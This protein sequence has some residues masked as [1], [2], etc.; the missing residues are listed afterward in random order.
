M[1]ITRNYMQ[2]SNYSNSLQTKFHPSSFST[3]SS[4]GCAARLVDWC[5]KTLTGTCNM[6]S[7]R[8]W[9]LFL[10]WGPSAWGPQTNFGLTY[11]VVNPR[12]DAT[13]GLQEII[14]A[15]L[16]N[17]RHSIADQSCPPP[18]RFRWIFETLRLRNGSNWTFGISREHVESLGRTIEQ[19]GRFRSRTQPRR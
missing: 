4:I 9:Q 2:V 11:R 15:R 17:R 14:L 18:S 10:E 19:P 8:T 13:Y 12:N 6:D 16:E 5:I 3:V 7:K 1:S